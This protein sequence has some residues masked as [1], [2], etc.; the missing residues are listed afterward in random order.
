M[1][2][3]VC[4]NEYCKYSYEVSEAELKEYGKYHEKCLICGSKLE[5][6]DK[7]LKEIVKQ[8]VDT[9]I[10]NNVDIW[11]KQL[12]IEYTIEMVERHKGT[13]IY[14]L[15]KAEIEKRGFK[16]KED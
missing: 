14:R 5:I 4:I 1:I 6:A 12:G 7:S 13:A 15:Y 9:E 3:L 16:L 8:D 11:F 10:K 2:R